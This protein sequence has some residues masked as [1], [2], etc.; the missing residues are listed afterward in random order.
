MNEL[1]AKEK[2]EQ[3]HAAEEDTEGHLVTAQRDQG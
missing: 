1:L 2:C 3:A